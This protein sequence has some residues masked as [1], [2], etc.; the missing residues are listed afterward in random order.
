[1][2][3]NGVMA[4]SQGRW[5]YRFRDDRI[6]EA[7]CSLASAAAVALLPEEQAG[8]L[9]AVQ[10]LP[11]LAPMRNSQSGWQCSKSASMPAA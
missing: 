5:T 3:A 9:D 7:D 1:M 11:R 10:G 4:D 8:G 6:V 2:Q